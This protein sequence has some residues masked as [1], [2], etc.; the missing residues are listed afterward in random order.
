MATNATAAAA[1]G[2]MRSGPTGA[3]AKVQAF[4][5]KAH[6]YWFTLSDSAGARPYAAGQRVLNGAVRQ[7]QDL[8]GSQGWVVPQGTEDPDP[9]PPCYQPFAP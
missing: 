7:V 8:A 4:S 2:T 6:Q 3:D 5:A 9:E 1:I